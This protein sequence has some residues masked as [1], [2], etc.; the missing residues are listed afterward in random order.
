MSKVEVIKNMIKDRI[1]SF[2]DY[3]ESIN[4][5]EWEDS[6]KNKLEENYS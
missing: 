5:K 6:W 3:T 1:N 4:Q 2:R